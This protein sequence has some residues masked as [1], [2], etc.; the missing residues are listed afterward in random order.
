[1]KFYV[2]KHD[3]HESVHR[4]TT[5]KITDKMQDSQVAADSLNVQSI[6]HVMF[7]AFLIMILV[8][9]TFS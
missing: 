3:A 9:C 5:M 8:C 7:M 4:D 6:A 2:W 1:M